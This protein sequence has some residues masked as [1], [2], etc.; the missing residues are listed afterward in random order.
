VEISNIEDFLAAKSE[1]KDIGKL[2]VRVVSESMSPW[3]N[4]G[5]ILTI[6]KCEIE[7]LKFPFIVAY[8]Y[9]R[10]IFLHIFWRF[11]HM[12]N[13]MGNRTF[14]TRS[15][16]APCLNEG[17]HSINNFLG[18]LDYRVSK[19]KVLF[20]FWKVLSNKIRFNKL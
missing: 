1:I 18:V 15:L 4:V 7:K 8:W 2:K 16:K 10:K 6:R 19:L 5:D 12:K 11:N 13:K 20:F 14:S 9:D 3:L 17:P